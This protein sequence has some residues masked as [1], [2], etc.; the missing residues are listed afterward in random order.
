MPDG[1]P[2]YSPSRPSKAA[3]SWVWS[4]SGSGSCTASTPVPRAEQ[5]AAVKQLL[6]DG[7]IRH[8]GLSN[9]SGGRHQG[10]VRIFRVATVQNSYNLVDRAVKTWWTTA[11]GTALVSFPSIRSMEGTL[12]EAGSIL[13]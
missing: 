6:D 3:A 4:R 13:D 2:T 5:F 9:V 11:R 7:V 8:A 12:P 1:R 10:R